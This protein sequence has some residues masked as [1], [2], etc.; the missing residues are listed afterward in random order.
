[1][2]SKAVLLVMSLVSISQT[3][4]VGA[5]HEVVSPDGK[6]RFSARVDGGVRLSLSRDGMPLLLPSAVGMDLGA[7]GSVGAG[8]RL[9]A[10][11]GRQE[12]RGVVR[13]LYGKRAEVRDHHN[14]MT[15]PFGGGFAMEMRAY[16]CGVAWRWSIGSPGRVK[17]MGETVALNFPRGSTFC[18]SIATNWVHSYEDFYTRG[19]AAAFPKEGM[20]VLPALFQVPG[21]THVAVTE[22]DLRDYPG[23]YLRGGDGGSVVAEFPRVVTKEAPGG[24]MDFHMEA[25]ERAVHLAESEGTRSFPWRVLV[26]APEDRDL[27]GN[28]LVH[29]LSAPHEG[30]FSW[31]R[32]GKVAWDWWNDWNLKGVPFRAGVN[33]ETYKHYIDFAAAHGLEYVN[34]DEGWSDQFDLFKL[35]LDV[36]E[37][38][39][40]ARAK[41]VGV[42]LWCVARTLDAQMAEAMRQFEAWGVAGLKV[43]F[44]DRDD[45]AMVNFYWRCAEA[46]A[47]HRLLV[48]FHGAHK[49]AGLMRTFPNV[50][51]QE[52]VRGLEYNKFAPPD[53]TTVEHALTIPF[54]RM[55]AGPM[56]YTPGAMRN[57]NKGGFSVNASRPMSHGTRCQQLAMYVVYDAPLAMLADSPTAYEAEPAMMEFLGTVPTTW[58]ETIPVAGKIGEHIAVARRKGDRWYIGGMCDWRGMEMELPLD[59]LGP[60]RW[61]FDLFADGINADRHAEDYRRERR[62]TSAEERLRVR[63][64]PGGGF[65]AVVTSLK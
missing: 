61:K 35:K 41:G 52:G 49:P 28:D 30:D 44:M 8:A 25:V 37:V 12:V 32:P 64:A 42:F 38:L 10:E 51:N 40:H 39:R 48:N 60:G 24:W 62:E 5:T 4:I 58:D 7:A 47:K 19:E 18:A 45:Q 36:V 20:A 26:V 15:L 43:D 54:A 11:P 13:P 9:S 33:V 34:L 23:L 22:S 14:R 57:A 46:A 21:G 17:V 16:D 65:V 55:L 56:D 1:M 3:D 27:V 59:F 50:V 53:G 6:L 31:V 63:L 29:L 2:A